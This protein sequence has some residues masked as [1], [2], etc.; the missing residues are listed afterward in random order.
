M[1]KWFKSFF[2]KHV[3]DLDALF[4]EYEKRVNFGG[5]EKDT[6]LV[7]AGSGARLFAYLLAVYVLHLL[8]YRFTKVTGTSG[9]AI[10][11]SIIAAL[12]DP[13]SPRAERGRSLR[14][15]IRIVMSIDVPSL[16]DPQWRI[17]RIAFGRSGMIKGNKLLRRFKKE[18]P[19]RFE[20]LKMPCEI[21]VFQTNMVD[22]A[23]R[24]LDSGNLPS[25][26]RAS[27]AIPFVFSPVR[28]G[29]MLLVDGGWQMNLA[30]PDGGKNVVALTFSTGSNFQIEEVQNNM[31]LGFKLIDGAIAE[32]V[33][34]AV[35]DAPD[36][37]LF[38]LST[39]LK[40]LN[41]FMTEEEKER[42]LRDGAESVMEAV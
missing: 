16:L 21:V 14:K 2:N 27:M 26:V 29:K 8:G 31:E 3:I 15:A 5:G 24:I 40:S 11:A 9:G 23:T 36:A 32:G 39:Q 7:V 20:D 25:A 18:L 34:R 37:K 28:R 6:H 13:A 4:A 17:S 38:T 35:E 10:L 41:F 12:Y 42:G 22:P 33:R 1:I 19:S 30:I